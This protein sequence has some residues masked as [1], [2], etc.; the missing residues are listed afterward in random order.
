MTLQERV[1]EHSGTAYR[2]A[3]ETKIH[4]A[5]LYDILNR[6]RAVSRAALAKLKAALG[7]DVGTFFDEDGVLIRK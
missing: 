2:F 6:K 1:V 7:N 3:K 4:R 5:A